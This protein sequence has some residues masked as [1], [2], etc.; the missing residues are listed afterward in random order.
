[1][2]GDPVPAAEQKELLCWFVRPAGA[3]CS[4][5]E[6]AVRLAE[7]LFRRVAGAKKAEGP[8]EESSEKVGNSS[9]GVL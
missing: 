7:S 4:E 9:G 5:E 2:K 1:M 8:V 3:L 6:T